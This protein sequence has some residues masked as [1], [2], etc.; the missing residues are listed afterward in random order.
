[1]QYV[2]YC[3]AFKVTYEP[4]PSRIKIQWLVWKMSPST[5]LL[6]YIYIYEFFE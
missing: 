5:N 3:N 6:K 2:V 1:M 4:C